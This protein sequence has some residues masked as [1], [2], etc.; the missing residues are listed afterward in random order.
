MRICP[1]KI[2]V[3]QFCLKQAWLLSNGDRYYRTSFDDSPFTDILRGD[4]P[5]DMKRLRYS[6][7]VGQ[8]DHNKILTISMSA[9]NKNWFFLPE[10]LQFRRKNQFFNLSHR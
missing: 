9:V 6:H 4:H 3:E 1:F 8:V 2:I 5:T 10:Q 7:F